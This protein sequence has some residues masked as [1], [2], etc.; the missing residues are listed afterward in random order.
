MRTK[1]W[2]KFDTLQRFEFALTIENWM[3]PLVRTTS[4]C[5]HRPNARRL[6]WTWVLLF[7]GWVLRIQSDPH[8][9]RRS[10]KDYVHLP[11]QNLCLPM[12]ALWIMQ[13]SSD[14]PMV[15]AQSFLWYGRTFSRDFHKWLLHLRRFIWTMSSSSWVGST[16]M[17]RKE[18]NSELGKCHF[19]VRHGI[20]LGHEIS[21]RGIEV[22]RAKVEVIAKLPPPKCIKDIRS[23][24]GHAGFY[25]RFIKD[26]TKI[27]LTNLL[28]KD[29]PF[30]FNEVCFKSWEKFK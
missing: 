12:H 29:V 22:D 21:R 18:P 26:F 24:L 5:L 10:G 13:H 28:A 30:D 9:R 14:I 16:K 1:S 6:G 11:I 20:V 7:P 8:C 23:F 27:P 4:R 25:R 15:H 17:Q 2:S 19:M 3:Q